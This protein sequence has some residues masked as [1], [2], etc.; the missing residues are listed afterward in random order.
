MSEIL[1][2]GEPFEMSFTDRVIEILFFVGI[3]VLFLFFFCRAPFLY[4]KNVA[5]RRTRREER[6]R[7]LDDMER[8]MQ[9]GSNFVPITMCPICMEDLRPDR[10]KPNNNTEINNN[11]NDFGTESTVETGESS[12]LRHRRNAEPQPNPQKAEE[13]REMKTKL[14]F[15]GH[16]FHK[17]CI[18]DWLARNDTCPICRRQRPTEPDAPQVPSGAQAQAQAQAVGADRDFFLY[19]NQ[20]LLYYSIWSVPRNLYMPPSGG[21]NG[22]AGGG[23]FTFGGGSGFG[24][25]GGGGGW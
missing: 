14:L 17:K 15:C 21:S 7:Q 24:G 4:F 1:K 3:I 8:R 6:R 13:E 12:T 2:T 9:Q 10:P 11:S 25:G 23:G 5:H 18:K 22:G 19:A 16:K 20:R